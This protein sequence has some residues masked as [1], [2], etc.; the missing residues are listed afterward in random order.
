[1]NQSEF[2]NVIRSLSNITLLDM[3]CERSKIVSKLLEMDETFKLNTKSIDTKRILELSLKCNSSFE[4]ISLYDFQ[5]IV[6]FHLDNKILLSSTLDLIDF[7][8]NNTPIRTIYREEYIMLRNR[9]FNLYKNDEIV[10]D[11]NKILKEKFNIR[12]RYNCT[13][14][15]VEAKYKCEKC[16]KSAYCSKKC[17]K[18][19]KNHKYICKSPRKADSLKWLMPNFLAL[20]NL[21][22]NNIP[23]N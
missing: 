23:V 6:K 11:T 8:E 10:K 2:E 7:L 12:K 22:K 17:Q 15:Q 13:M 4:K 19:N 1:M 3:I 20:R 9:Y 21:L 14:C 18:K 16:R 5:I